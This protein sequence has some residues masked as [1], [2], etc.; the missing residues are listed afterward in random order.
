MIAPHTAITQSETVTNRL[1]PDFTLIRSARYE[2]PLA[3][4]ADATIRR[5]T[6][7]GPWVGSVIAKFVTIATVVTSAKIPPKLN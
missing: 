6:E 5:S 1:N 4:K 2:V 7:V 3:R